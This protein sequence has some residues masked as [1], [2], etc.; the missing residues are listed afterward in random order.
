METYPT[1]KNAADA[2]R[3]FKQHLSFFTNPGMT[4]ET[5]AT[6]FTEDAVQEYPYAPAPYAT[7]VVGREE[8]TD[9]ISNV[10]KGATNWAFTNFSFLP[11]SDSDTVFVEFEGSAHVT[12]TG[13][14]YQQLYVGRITLR[15]GK[16]ALYREY[17]NPTW[18]LDAFV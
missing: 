8:I 4:R 5:Y 3:L 14:T 11:T 16:I 18:I 2:E 15:A 9:Y 17:W 7:K 6:L 10:I 13:K 1:N 12:S